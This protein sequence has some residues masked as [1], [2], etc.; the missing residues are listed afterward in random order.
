M[1]I[2]KTIRVGGKKYWIHAAKAKR[3]W[4]YGMIYYAVGT[5]VINVTDNKGK[6]IPSERQSIAFWHELTHALLH[7]MGHKLRSNEAFV[8]GFSKRLHSAIQSAE[9]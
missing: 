1:Q 4:N 5:I 8:D 9:F 7:D 2:P 3:R 6:P